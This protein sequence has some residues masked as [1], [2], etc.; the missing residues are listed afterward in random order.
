MPRRSVRT[1]VREELNFPNDQ[2]KIVNTNDLADSINSVKAVKQQQEEVVPSAPAI[3]N[4]DL[5]K[6]AIDAATAIQ[7]EKLAI[8]LKAKELEI[9]KTL[10]ERDLAHQQELESYK[11]TLEALTA[12][13]SEQLESIQSELKQTNTKLE[14]AKVAEKRM[15]EVFKL[16]GKANPVVQAKT[17]ALNVLTSTTSDRMVG[18]FAEF[19]AI[20]QKSVAVL[21]RSSLGN[22]YMM[23]DFREADK[24]AAE[25]R[26]SLIKDLE[27]FAK[28]N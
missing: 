3:S 8:E 1:E 15:A 23:N 27:A 7:G 13:T 9:E 6:Q 20:K 11:A 28:K 10:Q 12:K 22:A 2:V 21:K 16:H 25:N 14:D 17:P 26:D 19:E 5:I 4:A 24:F 18:A